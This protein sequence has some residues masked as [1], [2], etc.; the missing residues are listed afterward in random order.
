MTVEQIY[1]CECGNIL[2]VP[3]WKQANW[4]VGIPKQFLKRSEIQRKKHK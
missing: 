2:I 3:P 1:Y 4:K